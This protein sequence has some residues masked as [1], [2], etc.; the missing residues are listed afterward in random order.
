MWNVHFA[1]RVCG[2]L[3]FGYIISRF[4]RWKKAVFGFGLLLLFFGVFRRFFV[5]MA[6][7][8]VATFTIERCVRGYHVYK[9]LWSAEIG[10][11]LECA[12]ESD[13]PADRYA[14][15]T[16]KGDETV[17]H[18]PRKISRLCALFLER[19]GAISCTISGSRTPSV[20]LPQGGLELPCTLTF[21]GHP[22]LLA[23]VKEILATKNMQLQP[24]QASPEKEYG[25]QE[26]EVEAEVE[27]HCDSIE[28]SHEMEQQQWMKIRDIQLT[29]DDKC[30]LTGGR[31]LSDNHVNAVQ[32][33]LQAQHPNL[34]GMCST[35]V[36][37]R[38]K[39]P[40][41]GLQ[42]LFVRGNHWIALSTMDCR[43]GEVNV[44]DSLYEDQDA[45]TL[46]VI[47]G[48][49]EFHRPPVIINLM[50]MGKQKGCTDCGVFTAA[51]LTAL[52]MGVDVTK[53]R[54]D[55]GQMRSHL[56]KCLDS[57]E[58]TLFPSTHDDILPG[59]PVLKTLCH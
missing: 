33:L 1:I 40:S 35:L 31:Q 10:E 45:D 50:S 44:Y 4:C 58:M 2:I 39:L 5:V 48:L 54:F 14:V 13:N 24:K 15:A 28:C 16:K 20:D 57:K 49:I 3:R 12:R 55:Q 38:H 23:K 8:S 41:N 19:S 43:S 46:A 42:A 17:G 56:F 27:T 25:S 30:I 37:S 34:K 22:N 36:A 11:K 21:S 18:V 53:V 7:S 26:W 9:D 32:R 6:A 51:V 47:S 59:N 52:A 29:E